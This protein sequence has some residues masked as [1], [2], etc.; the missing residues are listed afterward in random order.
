MKSRKWL[1]AGCMMVCL[2]VM[3]PIVSAGVTDPNI[4]TG[5]IHV[6]SEQTSHPIVV[7]GGLAEGAKIFVDRDTFFYGDVGAFEGLDY[8]QTVMN[9]KTDPDVEYHVIINKPGTLFLFVDNRVGDGN[10]SN[11]PVLGGGVMN[12]AT[13]MGF[14]QTPYP[15]SFSEPATVYALPVSGDP[16]IIVLGPQNDG[17]SR[18]MYTIAAVPAG[19]NLAPVIVGVPDTAVVALPKKS[20]DIDGSIYDDGLPGAVVS[21]LWTVE[22]KPEGTTVQFN[23]DAMVIDPTVEFSDEG[24][25]TLKVIADDGDKTSEKTI[26]VTV[27][28][29]V[30]ALQATGNTELGNDSNLS[31]T[32]RSNGSGLGARNVDNRRRVAVV[33][34]NLDNA[35]DPQNQNEI[36]D[37]ATFNLHSQT[38]GGVITVFGVKEHLDNINYSTI[39]WNTCP[40]LPRPAPARNTPVSLVG[41]ELVGPLMV[42]SLPPVGSRETFP[43]SA[44]LTEFLN[45]DSDGTVTFLFTGLTDGV[46]NNIFYSTRYTSSGGYPNPNNPEQILWGPILLGQ[47]KV[48]TSAY[49]PNPPHQGIATPTLAQL[50]WTNPQPADPEGIITCDVYFG[51][52]EPNELLPNYGLQIIAEGITGSCVPVPYPLEAFKTYY[53]K[54]D[55]YDSS[56]TPSLTEGMIWEFTTDNAP[57]I[58][59]AGPDQYVWLN[60][61]GDPES[62]TVHLDGSVTDDGLPDGYLTRLWTQ[63]A[64]PVEVID[65]NGVIVAT[66]KV[67]NTDSITLVIPALGTYQFVLTGNDGAITGSDTVQV[68]VAADPCAAAQA[69]PDYE[70]IPGDFNGDCYVDIRDL[71][72]F[73]AHWLE[74]NSLASCVE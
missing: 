55:V 36:F 19:W 70:P 23:P 44:A 61:A 57:P 56:R 50:C 42:I 20:L 51:E 72:V 9:D 31:P 40:G 58:A 62:A 26:V 17:S 3:A 30:F 11:P 29:P 54:V 21:V 74:C 25:Y 45:S 13:E 69:K 32:S 15:I 52:N 14:T 66:Q 73:T 35:R 43:P 12:W 59:N 7:N 2:A 28:P 71:S 53:W 37:N 10:A 18:A 68:V 34:Y 65:P 5:V 27:S 24:V 60:N 22:D 49:K 8:I 38:R 67:A 1:A 4:I 64:G 39:T 33:S 47:R 46:D 41:A 48:A 16:N 6:N 63:T